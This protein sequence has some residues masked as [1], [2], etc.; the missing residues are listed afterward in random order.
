M[1]RRNF[2][3]VRVEKHCKRKFSVSRTSIPDGGSG[4]SVEVRED[5]DGF[6]RG[7][8]R[9]VRACTL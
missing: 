4:R 7:C 1:N 3:P 9:V 8:S 6:A 5:I 2:V